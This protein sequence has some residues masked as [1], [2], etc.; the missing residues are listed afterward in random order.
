MN[1]LILKEAKEDLE[2]LE[3]NKKKNCTYFYKIG[4]FFDLYK[5]YL[6]NVNIYKS[7]FIFCRF[8]MCGYI[9]IE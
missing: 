8:F 7:L 6:S 4:A 9:L 5:K 1:Y 2:V 3:N